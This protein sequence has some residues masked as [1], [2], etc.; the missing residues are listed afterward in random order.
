M[1]KGTLIF[2]ACLV[3][4]NSKGQNKYDFVG[5]SNYVRKNF[6][7]SRL[8]KEN[9]SN[10]F[11]LQIRFWFSAPGAQKKPKIYLLILSSKGEKCTASSYTFIQDRPTT[12]SF[13]LL[14][15]N[16]T[17][18]NNDSLLT[19]LKKD[20]LFALKSIGDAEINMLKNQK[21]IKEIVILGEG[22]SYY[23]IEILSK[24]KGEKIVFICPYT[25]YNE[26]KLQE[27][28]K[29]VKVITTLMRIMGFNGPC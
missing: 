17:F 2:I 15:E 6:S 19:I 5:D 29:P 3:L 1:K 11:D 14:K 9:V 26:Y 20:S 16:V 10:D 23:S 21:G 4:F 28:D 13:K 25:Y 22:G 8:I 18:Y 27:L 7:F 24:K 12:D